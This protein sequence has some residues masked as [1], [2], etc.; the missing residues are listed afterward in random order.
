MVKTV[1]GKQEH[2]HANDISTTWFFIQKCHVNNDKNLKLG[3]KRIGVNR[4]IKVFT[5]VRSR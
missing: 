3:F 5:R 4:V 2:L 1:I